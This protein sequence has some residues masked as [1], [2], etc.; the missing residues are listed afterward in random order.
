MYGTLHANNVTLV[1][2]TSCCEKCD[3]SAGCTG[4]WSQRKDAQLS[5]SQNDDKDSGL[6]KSIAVSTAKYLPVDTE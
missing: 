4:L 1:F 3:K 2:R 6:L 5:L